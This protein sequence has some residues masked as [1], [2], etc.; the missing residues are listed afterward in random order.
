[1][2]FR[3]LKTTNSISTHWRHSASFVSA[4][5]ILTLFLSQTV[6]AQREE[7]YLPCNSGPQ[8]LRQIDSWESEGREADI[9]DSGRPLSVEAFAERLISD[10]SQQLAL[11]SA[12]AAIDKGSSLKVIVNAWQTQL[13]FMKWWLQNRRSKTQRPSP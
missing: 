12:A 11:M 10:C 13:E 6:L 9:R 3:R 5:L 8:T 4:F 2:L 1:M 7:K